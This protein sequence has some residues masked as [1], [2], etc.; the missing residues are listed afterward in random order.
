MILFQFVCAVVFPKPA[1]SSTK[2]SLSL[3]SRIT[4][5]PPNAFN[6]QCLNNNLTCYSF[7]VS[8]QV[9][10]VKR[11]HIAIQGQWIKRATIII[12][13]WFIKLKSLPFRKTSVSFSFLWIKNSSPIVTE[14]QVIDIKNPEIFYLMKTKWCSFEMHNFR[15]ISFK[16]YHICLNSC[17]HQLGC[18]KCSRTEMEYWKIGLWL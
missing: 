4:H 7:V 15:V 6:S 18:K 14:M 13:I 17:D 3:N 11:E 8:Y 12:F 9:S 5:P 1:V 16:E 2:A 10:K